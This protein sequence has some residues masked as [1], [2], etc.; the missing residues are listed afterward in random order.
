M[1]IHYDIDYGYVGVNYSCYQMLFNEML[2][3]GEI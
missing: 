1:K 3:N 2:R